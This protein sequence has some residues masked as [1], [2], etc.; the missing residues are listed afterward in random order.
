VPERSPSSAAA[1]RAWRSGCGGETE[2][3]TAVSGSRPRER[4]AAAARRSAARRPQRRSILEGSL[5]WGAAHEERRNASR[6]RA[7][8]ARPSRSV[9]W[10]LDSW[11]RERK[12]KW[13]FSCGLRPQEATGEAE[14]GQQTRRNSVQ[15]S[16]LT[17]STYGPLLAALSVAAKIGHT[18]P[19]WYLAMYSFQKFS[20]F[21]VTSNIGHMHGTLNVNKKTN[22]IVW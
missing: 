9:C 14:L 10:S 7:G 17:C 15:A 6:S 13:T 12:R 18:R 8:A 21:P 22:Y 11:R 1:G 3:W 5:A 4:A 19:N 2:A 16:N 20:R